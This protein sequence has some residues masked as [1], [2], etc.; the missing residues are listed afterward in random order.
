M[1]QKAITEQMAKVVRV[2][3]QEHTGRAGAVAVAAA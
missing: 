2:A 3:R 1:A